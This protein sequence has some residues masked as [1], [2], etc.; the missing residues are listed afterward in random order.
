MGNPQADAWPDTQ[1]AMTHKELLIYTLSFLLNAG[2]PFT[3]EH[4]E[5]RVSFSVERVQALT[6]MIGKAS[7]FK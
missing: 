7:K 6:T 4:G 1:V 2:R 5:M 3:A